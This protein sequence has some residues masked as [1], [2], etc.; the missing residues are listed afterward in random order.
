MSV[1]RLLNKPSQSPE[2]PA[3]KKQRITPP[4]AEAYGLNHAAS[5]QPLFASRGFVYNKQ[6]GG[7]STALGQRLKSDR[8][9]P[10]PLA[11]AS[12]RTEQTQEK[13]VAGPPTF[14][15]RSKAPTNSSST[16]NR[17][18]LSKPKEEPNAVA[19]E[20]QPNTSGPNKSLEIPKKNPLPPKQTIQTNVLKQNATQ[21]TST[22]LKADRVVNSA[23]RLSKHTP[24]TSV[25]LLERQRLLLV[26]KRDTS[27]LDSFIYGQPG[28]SQLLPPGVQRPSNRP[29]PRKQPKVLMAHIDP[30]IHRTRP[31]SAAW[32][33]KKEEEIKKRGGRKANFGKA[34]QRLKQQRA[35]QNPDEFEAS[36]PD[37]VR[38]NEDWVKALHWF[39]HGTRN[40]TKE[41]SVTPAAS[42]A[43]F[44]RPSS[45]QKPATL[46]T[47]QR[48][49]M[50]DSQ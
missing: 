44:K 29:E 10:P 25:P 31:H 16:E 15:D 7:M 46:S 26:E 2:G 13:Q 33:R 23:P 50:A 12:A 28:S 40:A 1:Q 11:R 22:E 21:P 38:S 14:N 24:T 4:R 17:L 35:Q 32:Y 37:R 49:F 42:P 9:S 41:P 3:K 8:I 30:R 45:R 5:S 34:S 27:I 47:P 43:R 39:Q 20:T 48:R 18:K 6:N 19:G 36:L